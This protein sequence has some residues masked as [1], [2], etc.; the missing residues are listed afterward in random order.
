MIVK[1]FSALISD[2]VPSTL[3]SAATVAAAASV[4]SALRLVSEYRLPENILNKPCIVGLAI[5]LYLPLIL[6]LHQSDRW[7]LVSVTVPALL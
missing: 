6:N 3:A 1:Y 4:F 2:F 7:Y 5:H